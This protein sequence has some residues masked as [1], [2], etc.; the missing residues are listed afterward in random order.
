MIKDNKLI[1][2]YIIFF[3]LFLLFLYLT[4]KIPQQF[5]IYSDKN[6]RNYYKTYYSNFINL[7]NSEKKNNRIFFIIHNSHRRLFT[8]LGKKQNFEYYN[9]FDHYHWGF[10]RLLKT[11]KVELDYTFRLNYYSNIFLQENKISIN[12]E[13]RY[14]KVLNNENIKLINNETLQVSNQVNLKSNFITYSTNIDLLFKDFSNYPLLLRLKIPLI[15]N[16]KF[17]SM[18]ISS[19]N[20]KLIS[21]LLIE[22]TSESE[23][24]SKFIENIFINNDPK[25][26]I[27][28]ARYSN[29]D[30]Y[31]QLD[32]FIMERKDIILD[33]IY[34]FNDQRFINL[35]RSDQFDY[36]LLKKNIL[37]FI[38]EKKNNLDFKKIYVE[39]YFS[40]SIFC[41]NK[42][43][44]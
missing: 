26:S 22:N 15:N 31:L 6:F 43:S 16:D 37:N 30:R 39:K 18:A 8:I 12:K 24:Y 1:F 36:K 25:I 13:C 34:T 33:N 7:N 20:N 42:F 4:K 9:T 44:S 2:F 40:K 3:L 28:D 32:L 10:E 14:Y 35:L 19:K 29:N 21:F 27:I 5:Q 38:E 23:G 41:V 17:I 11:F